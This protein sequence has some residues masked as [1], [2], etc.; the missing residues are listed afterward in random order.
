MDLFTREKELREQF[1]GNKVQFLLTEVDTATTFCHVANTSDDPEKKR[2]NIANACEGY[3]TILKFRPGAQFDATSKSEFDDKMA[4]L[5][6]LLRELG[7]HVP[8]EGPVEQ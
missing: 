5:Q 8:S 6:S 1:E 2:R 4:H 7:Q 3:N